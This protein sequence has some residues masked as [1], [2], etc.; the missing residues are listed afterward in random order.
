[1]NAKFKGINLVGDVD[2][3]YSTEIPYY[4]A[5]HSLVNSRFEYGI[6]NSLI[7]QDYAGVHK[8]VLSRW[9]PYAESWAAIKQFEISKNSWSGPNL[10][11]IS[12]ITNDSV[13]TTQL[14][15]YKV[16][17]YK[18][19]NNVSTLIEEETKYFELEYWLQSNFISDKDECFPLFINVDMTQDRV[20]EIG[21]LQPMM[22]RY[23]VIIKNSMTDY[24]TGTFRAMLMTGKILEQLRS[25]QGY[26]LQSTQEMMDFK[27]KIIDFLTNGKPK[28]LRLVPGDMFIVN[29]VGNVSVDWVAFG[30]GYNCQISFN[31]VEVADSHSAE[32]VERVSLTY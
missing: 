10:E 29:I 24:N 2:Q 1:M 7:K 16:E 12:G 13:M 6:F 32:A 17:Y 30:S 31:W 4:D 18:W 23:P 22:S 21:Q 25:G 14:L 26:N 27:N 5:G 9:V 28:C 19:V 20:Q 3:V 11:V 8:I 15:K